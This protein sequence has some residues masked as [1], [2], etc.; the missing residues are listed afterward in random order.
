[1]YHINTSI[2]MHISKSVA[3]IFFGILDR[4]I[5][6]IVLKYCTVG[7]TAAWLPGSTLSSF[8]CLL[9]MSYGLPVSAWFSL[10]FKFPPTSSAV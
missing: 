1:M 10:G 7:S 6:N 3:F 9:G 8:Y 5:L 4:N 2:C